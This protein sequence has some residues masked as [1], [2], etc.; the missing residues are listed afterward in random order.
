[1]QG[2]PGGGEGERGRLLEDWEK[3]RRGPEIPLLPIGKRSE[4]HQKTVRTVSPR[5]AT[6]RNPPGSR[7]EGLRG[8][9]ARG[10]PRLIPKGM[11]PSLER[12]GREKG[13]CGSHHLRALAREQGPRGHR[14]VKPSPLPGMR[15]NG[16]PRFKEDPA[17][18]TGPLGDDLCDE[19]PT[20]QGRE[21][22]GLP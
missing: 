10:G 7:R 22:R 4:N 21:V 15:G 8:G 2:S 11:E 19:S 14:G 12:P 20:G 3:G 16:A 9:C 1:V 5:A 6:G 18:G 13:R 17:P